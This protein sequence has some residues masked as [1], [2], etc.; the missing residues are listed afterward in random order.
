MPRIDRN[1][2]SPDTRPHGALITGASSGLGAALAEALARPG[3][4]LHLGGRDADRLEAVAARCRKLG[5]QVHPRA[6]D[7]TDRDATA[8]WIAGAAGL[9]RLDLVIANAGISGGVGRD[10]IEPPAQTRAVFDT[11][12]LGALG[13]IVAAAERMRA[14]PVG[15]DGLRGSIAAIASIS[16]FLPAPVAPGYAASKAALD[17]WVLAQAGAWARQGVRLR[18]VCPGFIRSPMTARNRF[19]MPGLMDADRAAG[20]VLAGIASGK[21]RVVFPRWLAAAGRAVDLLP[22]AWQ[23]RVTNKGGK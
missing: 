5:A 20:L 11:N 17:S 21:R 2:H 4:V 9:G 13:T 10:G 1:D 22:P 23:E 3:A 15:P 18:S 7:I 12:L 16:A 19:P 8:A 6:I 14:Q